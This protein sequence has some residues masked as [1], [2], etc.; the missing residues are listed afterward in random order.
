MDE[1]CSGPVDVSH[2]FQ[3][4]LLFQTEL[5]SPPEVQC[6]LL[7]TTFP[8]A[9]AS[10]VPVEL[11]MAA[12]QGSNIP[13]ATRNKSFICNCVRS[14][15]GK[16]YTREAPGWHVQSVLCSARLFDGCRGHSMALFHGTNVGRLVPGYKLG[17]AL[18]TGAGAGMD[19][20][21]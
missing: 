4:V 16:I 3:V 17:A 8:S 5:Y 11:V 7:M 2:V 12:W 15:P 9:F 6:R 14:S 20:R 10:T 1:T 21:V 19:F 13:A 18:C